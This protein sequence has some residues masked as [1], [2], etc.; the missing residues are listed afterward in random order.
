LSLGTIRDV[1]PELF[2][3]DVL[4]L[5]D[6]NPTS[7]LISGMLRA[8]RMIAQGAYADAVGHSAPDRDAVDRRHQLS[9][10]LIEAYVRLGL[11]SG[12][13]HTIQMIRNLEEQAVTQALENIGQS[14]S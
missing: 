5:F 7:G 2:T 14:R 4:P 6:G 1:V 10:T 13:Q 8:E 9:E 11:A 12:S 3:Q